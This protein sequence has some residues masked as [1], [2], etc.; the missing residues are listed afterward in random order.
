[1][2]KISIMYDVI[3]SMGTLHKLL[4]SYVW[5]PVEYIGTQPVLAG[6]AVIERESEWV[7]V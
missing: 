6:R 7:S 2:G 4:Y 3:V 5:G 1:M